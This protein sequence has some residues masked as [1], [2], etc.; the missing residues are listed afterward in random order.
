MSRGLFKVEYLKQ[1]HLFA[2]DKYRISY[3]VLRI[4]EKRNKVNNGKLFKR[5]GKI[6]FAK[7]FKGPS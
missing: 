3:L 6:E 1:C 2:W 4:A 7:V 5:R